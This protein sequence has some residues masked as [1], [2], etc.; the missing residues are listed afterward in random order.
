[1][2]RGPLLAV[3][4]TMI[5]LFT[6]LYSENSLSAKAPVV[7][8]R[9]MKDVTPLSLDNLVPRTVSTTARNKIL[10]HLNKGTSLNT[11]ISVFAGPNVPSEIVTDRK[12]SLEKAIRF[13]SNHY[14]PP[15]YKFLLFTYY[16]AAYAEQTMVE[17]GIHG[18]PN[19]KADI[20]NTT[21]E[22][23]SFGNAGNPTSFYICISTKR[24]HEEAQTVPH[25]YTH[26]VAFHLLNN[27]T[28]ITSLPCW[29]SEG[30]GSFYGMQLGFE[31]STYKRYRT[32]MERGMA[33]RF[34]QD[35]GSV[36]GK[37]VYEIL[38]YG[39]DREVLEMMKMS[40]VPASVACKPVGA[41]AYLFGGYA[42]EVTVALW[43]V[44]AIPGY[45]AAFDPSVDWQTNWERYF[46]V[47]VDHFYTALIPYFRSFAEQLRW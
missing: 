46:G 5:T 15:A 41:M 25:E 26:T 11:Q 40:A 34:A 30:F 7:P 18:G 3:L 24:D 39:S 16:D 33:L 20:A 43:G 8:K 28:S 21:P 12:Q 23:C 13:W 2:N 9:A 38:K 22:F 44:D 45:I 10:A 1:M 4:I 42:M 29:I 31:G 32:D 6:C 27:Q 19:F 14:Q 17:Q 36:L 35:G 47:S 37:S